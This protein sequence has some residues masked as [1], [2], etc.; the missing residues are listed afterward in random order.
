MR[1]KCVPRKV[2]INRLRYLS[3]ILQYLRMDSEENQE[4]HSGSEEWTHVDQGAVPELTEEQEKQEK[5]KLQAE[6][7][8]S[9]Q[10]KTQEAESSAKAV[11]NFLGGAAVQVPTPMPSV[12]AGFMTEMPTQREDSVYQPTSFEMQ[13]IRELMAEIMRDVVTS[14]SFTDEEAMNWL[15]QIKHGAT[16]PQSE[17]ESE[18]AKLALE[19]EQAGRFLL[20]LQ[21]RGSPNRHVQN[22][23]S[24][25]TRPANLEE[26]TPEQAAQLGKEVLLFG[27]H[28]GHTFEDVSQ[29]DTTYCK[30][31]LEHFANRAPKEHPQTKVFFQYLSHKFQIVRERA[32]DAGTMINKQTGQAVPLESVL[33]KGYPKMLLRKSPPTIRNPP[34]SQAAMNLAIAKASASP[35]LGSV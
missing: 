35:S 13:K 14:R 25:E 34:A 17:A 2:D 21:N 7:L 20:E 8:T 33:M 15:Q 4:I 16:V 18:A 24:Q 27:K 5:N 29:K 23:G 28:Q 9:I 30:W 22:Q 26:T 32:K 12:P 11:E 1:I 3:A 6:A 19:C 10:K 31:A